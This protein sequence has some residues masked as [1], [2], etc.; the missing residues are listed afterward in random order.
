MPYRKLLVQQSNNFTVRVAN[1]TTTMIAATA[2]FLN[3][4]TVKTATVS[5]T[6]EMFCESSERVVCMDLTLT[7]Y[8]NLTMYDENGNL[9]SYCNAFLPEISTTESTTIPTT[10][11]QSTKI[12]AYKLLVETIFYCFPIFIRLSFFVIELSFFRKH[13]FL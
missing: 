4:I 11:A 12:L 1:F 2:N 7:P 9:V 5:A 8:C 6:N 13:R 10:T 3:L